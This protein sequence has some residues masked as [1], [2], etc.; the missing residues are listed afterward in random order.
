M[1]SHVTQLKIRRQGKSAPTA[2]RAANRACSQAAGHE[3]VVPRVPFWKRGCDAVGATILLLGLSPVLLAVAA[4]VKCT[5][6]GPMLF[7]QRRFG[8]GGR[9]FRIWKFRTMR[10]CV[11]QQPHG[12]YV[13]DLMTSG[14]KMNKLSVPDGLIPGG[15]LLRATGIDELPQLVNVLLGQMSLVGPRPDVIPPTEYQEHQRLRFDVLPGITGLWQ[16][17]GKNR[18]TFEQMIELDV[19]YALRCSPWL[20]LKIVLRTIPVVFRQFLDKRSN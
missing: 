6:R 15:A 16:V 10:S 18:T 20:D 13:R 9:P 14:Q 11:D 5:M 17:S 1:A 19:Q 12:Q 8:L 2:G 4:Y 7:R 3:W